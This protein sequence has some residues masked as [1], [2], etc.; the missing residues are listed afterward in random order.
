MF[1]RQPRATQ[2]TKEQTTNKQYGTITIVLDQSADTSNPVRITEI[3]LRDYTF[4]ANMMSI[5]VLDRLDRVVG[6]FPF[7]RV[8]STRIEYGEDNTQ[9][10]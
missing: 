5:I 3:F 6:V 4:I 2:P 7:E 8:V 1:G 10:V 9:Q